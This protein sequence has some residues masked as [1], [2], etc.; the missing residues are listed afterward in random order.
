MTKELDPVAAAR[1]AAAHLLAV[2]K[3]EDSFL[4]FVQL[5]HPTYRLQPFQLELI[6][7][8]DR[9]EKGTLVQKPGPHGGAP[10]T[11]LMINMPPRYGKSWLAS[12]LFPVYYIARQPLRK[13]LGASY[14][15]ILAKDVGRK[16]RQ[17]AEMERVRQ[18]FPNFEF[19]DAKAADFW[20]T[21]MGGQYATTGI[22]GTTSGRP[23]NLMIF[24]DP[25]KS[26]IEADSPSA[27]NRAWDYYTSALLFRKEPLHLPDGTSIPPIEIIIMT[28]WHPD[29]IGGRIQNSQ[30][31]K[32]G[33]WYHVNYPARIEKTQKV[34]RSS[35]PKDDPEWM[36]NEKVKYLPGRERYVNKTTVAALWPEQNSLEE[37]ARKEQLAPREF[38]ALFMQ[39]P[40]VQGGNR[41]K[42]N[43]W[44]W[45][46]K[47]PEPEE[48]S[49]TIIGV[50][51]ASKTSKQHDYS[52]FMVAAMSQLGDIY[53]LDVVRGKWLFP[54]LKRMMVQINTLW[55]G[56]GLRA[57][58]VE[59]KSSGQELIAEMRRTTG[60]SVIAHRAVHD[61]VARLDFVSPM[62]EGG[63]VW[64]PK[65]AP[66]LDEFVQETSAFPSGQH[67][68]QVD[69]LTI[70]LDE[71]GRTGVD[72]T[73]VWGALPGSETS[74]TNLVAK[75]RI[76]GLGHKD[77][78]GHKMFRWGE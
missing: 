22:G 62:I 67:D 52:V 58:Y 1:K 31:W 55:R 68:D 27:R 9:L 50:D 7:V 33:L 74:L 49:T 71:L 24:D 35:L 78:Q 75:G 48:L 10:C 42:E 16:S 37:L 63:R 69:A 51:T 43:W 61:K 32:D 8:L 40:Y 18:A 54:D 77:W 25:V 30:D 47:A 2:R 66:W 23:A 76:P 46:D 20:N 64:L 34:W 3:A 53:I 65:A 29:D 56:K 72:N 17:Y 19:G 70:V 59:D 6:S 38:A 36:P 44:R 14:N 45:Y 5:L 57:F 15:D 13:V 26:R 41:I 4:G 12:W 60:I 21:S 39:Q 28:R 73:R 11:R